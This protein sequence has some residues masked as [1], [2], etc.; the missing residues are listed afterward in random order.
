MLTPLQLTSLFGSGFSF[1]SASLLKL[2][3][4]PREDVQSLC[5]S[6]QSL[7]DHLWLLVGFCIKLLL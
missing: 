6:T 2:S 4:D 3:D 1:I 7:G 5:S